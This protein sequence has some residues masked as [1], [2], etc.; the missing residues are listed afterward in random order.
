MRRAILPIEGTTVLDMKS[1]VRAALVVALA[2]AASACSGESAQDADTPEAV[3]SA[4]QDIAT[5]DA[6]EAAAP[7]EA[8]AAAGVA[9]PGHPMV[10]PMPALGG[11][12]QALAEHCGDYPAAEL[13]DLKKQQ[14]ELAIQ[15]GMSGSSFDAEYSKGYNDTVAKIRQ[16]TPAEREKACAQLE[17]FQQ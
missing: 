12:M 3:V 2:L 4:A 17:A 7:A 13:A 14:R 11:G 16:G 8:Q 6:P 9:Q 5:G 10:G 1:P 15:S